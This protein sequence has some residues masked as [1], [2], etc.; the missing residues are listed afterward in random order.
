VRTITVRLAGRKYEIHQLPIK[1][2]R[3]WREQH[4][5]PLDQALVAFDAVV[6]LT[7]AEFP[8]GDGLVKAVGQLLSAHAGNVSRTLLNSTD[9]LAEALFAYSPELQADREHI[10]AEG[11]PDEIL[12]AFLEVLKFSHPL[13]SLAALVMS[14]GQLA[15]MTLPSSPAPSGASGK[16]RSTRSRRTAS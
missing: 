12:G 6:E 11:F 2:D 1:A 9:L 13:G 8:D 4:R 14:P 16:T 3:A 15:R 5:G 7:K 10:E